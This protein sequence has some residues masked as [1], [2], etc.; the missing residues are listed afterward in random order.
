MTSRINIS[1]LAK[2]TGFAEST[3]RTWMCRPE[4]AKYEYKDNYFGK[5]IKAS[6]EYCN[7][8]LELF[9]E[10]L[11]RKRYFRQARKIRSCK[12]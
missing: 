4:F 10:F 8:F 12:R 9:A 5:Y 2:I 7:D 11:E 6:F 1:G 3:I